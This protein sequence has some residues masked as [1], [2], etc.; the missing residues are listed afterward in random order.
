M[1]Y[2]TGADPNSVDPASYA[3]SYW[4]NPPSDIN[5][6]EYRNWYYQ[7]CSYFYPQQYMDQAAGSSAG[8]TH[9]LA[10]DPAD[11]VPNTNTAEVGNNVKSEND[12]KK[13][14]K[15]KNDDL[16]TKH[17]PA[18]PPGRFYF[19]LSIMHILLQN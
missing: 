7:Y 17:K 18:E 16:L 14:K 11:M 3:N 9:E 2:G 15:K 13:K 19:M 12:G 6:E 1:S 10:S 8:D 5:S 4:S